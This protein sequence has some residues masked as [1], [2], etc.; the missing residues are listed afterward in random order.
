M[1][2][3]SESQQLYIDYKKQY[4]WNADIAYDY[5]VLLVRMDAERMPLPSCF[6]LWMILPCK[7]IA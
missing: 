5:A 2:W 1:N 6:L 3:F 4:E 7:K